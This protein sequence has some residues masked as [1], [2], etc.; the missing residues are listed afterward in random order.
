M[1]RKEWVEKRLLE[2]SFKEDK[3]ELDRKE[4]KELEEEL[5]TLQEC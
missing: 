2:L 1:T 5:K 4:E 3:D